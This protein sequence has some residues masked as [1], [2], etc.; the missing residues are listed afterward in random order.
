MSKNNRI[1][2][3]KKFDKSRWIQMPRDVIAGH[4]VLKQLPEV[5]VDLHITGPILIISGAHTMETVGNTVKELLADFEVHTV[6]VG[7]ITYEEIE[8]VE[9]FAKERGISLMIG[10]GGGR[11]IDTAKITSY[12]LDIPF[13]SIPT[14][15]S[16]DG[17]A[18]SRASVKTEEGNVSLAAHPPIAII[19]DTG[20]LAQ[21]PRRMMASGFA[22][23]VANYT[24]ALDWELSRNRTGEKV[25]EYALTLSMITA[26]LMVENA[27]KI[28]LCDENAAWIVMKALFSS[29]VAMSIA[30]SSRPAS[31]GEHKFAHM[32]E[33][34]APDAALH[35]EACGIGTIIS[36][37]LHGADWRKVRT[38]LRDVG[39]PTKPEDIG[40]SREIVI[41]AVMR[42]HEIRPERY[43]IF[44]DHMTIEKAAA[45]V[46]ALYEE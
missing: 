22:D 16:H 24:A 21:A 28:R 15:A 45:A 29:G 7:K 11:V 13:I 23:V 26:E 43:T 38:A 10:V 34:L 2:K 12:N 20:I 33:I 32:L 1:L 9:E 17:I 30:G 39:A 25:S 41:D 6:L 8:R 35:G 27:N 14:A 3:N 5:I 46:A 4:D 18:S 40:L 37:Y 31:G 44:D 19:A 36:M 42:A